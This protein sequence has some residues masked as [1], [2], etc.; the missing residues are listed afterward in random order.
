MTKFSI[1]V[2]IYNIAYYQG[3]NLFAKCMESIL[4]QTYPHFEVLLVDDGSTDDAPAQCD[5]YALADTRV[6]VIHQENKGAGAA[7]NA[8]IRHSTGDYIFF[9]DADDEIDRRSCEVFA[10]IIDLY[11]DL[12]IIGSNTLLKKKDKIEYWKFVPIDTPIDGEHFIILQRKNRATFTTTCRHILKNSYLFD[13]KMFFREDLI[14]GEDGEWAAN[15]YLPANK[16]ITSNFVHYKYNLNIMEISRS[17]P[18][19]PSKR[20]FGIMSYCY[21]LDKKYSEIQDLELR[22]WMMDIL[23]EMW[24]Y[25]FS[26]GKFYEK[27]Y[28]YMINKDFFKGKG[29]SLKSKLTIRLLVISP[30]LYYYLVRFHTYFKTIASC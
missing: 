15:L 27:K 18:K 4:A 17:N 12:D 5:A 28:R 23:L 13:H 1:I 14:G 21:A 22:F 10:Q 3:Q 16:V 11:P 6:V 19:D 25:A 29:R 30:F 7:R 26:L 8:G 9:V 20:S 24:L 2:P